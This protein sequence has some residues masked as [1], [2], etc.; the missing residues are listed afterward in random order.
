MDALL[1]RSTAFV[2]I[3]LDTMHGAPCVKL[4]SLV[5]LRRVS[6]RP[7]AGSTCP[8]LAETE[9]PGSRGRGRRASPP[10][11]PRRPRPAA[12]NSRR[13]AAQGPT[14]SLPPSPPRTNCKAGVTSSSWPCDCH[15]EIHPNQPD[16]HNPNVLAALPSAHK[17][18]LCPGP[19]RTMREATASFLPL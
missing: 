12:R 16:I 10:L 14:Q 9:A 4:V 6:T 17:A 18:T 8:E 7:R 13:R 2:F 5:V 11:G 15:P 19:L 1:N 3:V